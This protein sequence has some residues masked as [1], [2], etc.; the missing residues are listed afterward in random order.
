MDWKPFARGSAA[1]SL[2]FAVLCGEEK[3]HLHV[4]YYS[5]TVIIAEPIVVTSIASSFTIAYN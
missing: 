2:P 3:Q 5:E 1:C 4:G